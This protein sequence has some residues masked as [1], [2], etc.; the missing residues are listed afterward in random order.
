MGKDK[1]RTASRRFAVSAAS[2]A[3]VVPVLGALPA[4]AGTVTLS[5]YGY[6][7]CMKP[8]GSNIWSPYGAFAEAYAYDS[9]IRYSA[10]SFHIYQ[11]NSEGHLPD[12]G[13]GGYDRVGG[14]R[15][16]QAS[17]RIGGSGIS[18]CTIGV[19]WGCTVN[20]NNSIA[21]DSYDSGTLSNTTGSIAL[22]YGGANVYADQYGSI[23]NYS[24]SVTTTFSYNGYAVRASTAN[25]SDF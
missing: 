12:C 17:W 24:H 9:V 15:R 11:S 20:T 8:G 23:N 22:N 1:P 5:D 7:S 19:G 18:S 25:Y 13:P 16:L 10:R 21:T 14:T 3:I 2:L 6:S 4:Y